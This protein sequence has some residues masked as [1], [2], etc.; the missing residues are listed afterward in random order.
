MSSNQTRQILCLLDI[1]FDD[2]GESLHAVSL[3]RHPRFQRF[4]VAREFDATICKRQSAGDNTSCWFRQ[5]N[6]LSG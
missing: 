2:F 5:G 3:Q 1:L 4:E 6:S